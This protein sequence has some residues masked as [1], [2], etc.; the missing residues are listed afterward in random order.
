M[1][2]DA[3]DDGKK[4]AKALEKERPGT[5]RVVSYYVEV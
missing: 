2:A 5:Y 1:N 3:E 4:I